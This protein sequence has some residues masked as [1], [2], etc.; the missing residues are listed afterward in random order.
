MSDSVHKSHS[1]LLYHFVCPAKYRK[2]VFSDGVDQGLKEVF[3]KGIT[4]EEI[5]MKFPEVKRKLWGR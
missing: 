3:V 1:V 5:F 2:V 4:A